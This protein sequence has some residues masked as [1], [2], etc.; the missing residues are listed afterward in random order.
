MVSDTWW[1]PFGRGH[2]KQKHEEDEPTFEYPKNITLKDVNVKNL[3]SEISLLNISFFSDADP[4]GKFRK[5]FTNFIVQKDQNYPV[6]FKLECYDQIIFKVETPEGFHTKTFS[7]TNRNYTESFVT[8]M[9]N[10][11]EK[12]NFKTDHNQLASE[13]SKPIA[14]DYV[15]DQEGYLKTF[16]L[17]Q[18]VS[19]GFA[20]KSYDEEIIYQLK[21]RTT[22]DKFNLFE[23]SFTTTIDVEN[24]CDMWKYYA[25]LILSYPYYAYQSFVKGDIDAYKPWMEF[26]CAE[27][28]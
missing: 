23:L 20:K 24:L 19:T 22:A 7:C 8:R 1:N 26:Y 10:L 16:D 5:L 15:D 2:K 6:D 18:A 14:E 17:N 4:E 28:Q 12:V 21:R 11:V 25:M 3:F 9:S 27:A 13:I